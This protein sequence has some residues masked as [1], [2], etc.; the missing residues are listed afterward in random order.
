M[1]ERLSLG[2]KLETR[3]A[4]SRSLACGR[5]FISFPFRRGVV[6]SCVGTLTLAGTAYG[7]SLI[8]DT[9]P[10]LSGQEIDK[11]LAES[12]ELR[13]QKEVIVVRSSDGSETEIRGVNTA[14]TVRVP[15]ETRR[16]EFFEGQGSKTGL[17]FDGKAKRMKLRG[18]VVH[19]TVAR[20]GTISSGVGNGLGIGTEFL[21]NGDED[22]YGI[23]VYE[24]TYPGGG[25]P[26]S[27]NN[28]PTNAWID[29]RITKKPRPI[30][31]YLRSYE[32][33]TWRLQVEPGVEIRS[34]I[35]ISYHHSTATGVPDGTK[36]FCSSYDRPASK[37]FSYEKF[38]DFS[39]NTQPIRAAELFGHFT[40]YM[41][42]YKGKEYKI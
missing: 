15:D 9:A 13:S 41:T 14:G 18:R 3:F 33:V 31:L 16:R 40:S 21:P 2:K 36:V 17:D 12:S 8:D 42:S 5:A 27:F 26:H 37:N 25:S 10:P 11:P 30:V 32:P 4:L 24:G 38:G 22:L 35:V 39:D 6:L 28:H 20:N 34:L 7:D 19:S 1:I 29:L 23:A